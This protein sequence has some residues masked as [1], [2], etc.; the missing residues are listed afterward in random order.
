MDIETL[1]T[2]KN[3][4]PTAN[5]ITVLR[6]LLSQTNPVSLN[7]LE[8]SLVTLDKS[9][10]FRVLTLFSQH[11]VVHCIED[12]SGSMKYEVCGS[13]HHHHPADMHVHFACTECGETTCLENIKVPMVELPEG[14]EPQAVNYVV[15]GRCSRCTSR[16]R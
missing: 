2:N 9:S 14:F 1:L 15:K 12:G 5:R 3:V 7:Q 8:Q 16:I 11:G 10:I 13:S 6:E 4:R